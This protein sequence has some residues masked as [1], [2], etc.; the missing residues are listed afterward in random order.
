MKRAF[1]QGQPAAAEKAT[2]VLLA[3]APLARN[4]EGKVL[5]P[6]RLHMLFRGLQGIYACSNPGCPQKS[7]ESSELGLGRIYLRKP[8]TGVLNPQRICIRRI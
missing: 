5:Y 7:H 4:A 6:A 8:G 3:I 1:P 2:N